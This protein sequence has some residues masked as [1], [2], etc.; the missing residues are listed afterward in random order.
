MLKRSSLLLAASLVVGLGVQAPAHAAATITGAGA[1][2]P[3]PVYSEWSDEYQD[4]TGAG[5]NYQAIGSGGGIQ[6]IQAGTVTFGASDAPLSADEQ[7]EHDLVQFP[8]IMGGVVP[9]ANLKLPEGKTLRLDGP[10]LAAIYQGKITSWDDK[11]IAALNEG[12]DLPSQ[13]ITPVYRS[14]GSGTNFNFT[15]YLAQVSD[16]FK[17]QVGEG[18]SVSWPAGVGAQANGGVASQVSKVPGAIGYVEYAYAKQ[19]HLPALELK[20]QDGSFVAPSGETFAAAASHADWKGTPGFDV[21]LTNQPGADSWPITAVSYILMHADAKDGNASKQA[22]DFFNWAY[23][24]GSEAATKLDYV[25]IPKDV[26][27]I[28]KENVWSR[29]KADGKPVWTEQ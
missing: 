3:Y 16:D 19:N 5:L 29:I 23:T 17:Q 9:V 27:E 8:M 28:V 7:K 25:A 2:F 13:R 15:H 20:N 24:N 6:Q 21:I 12:V 11:R 10:T 14:D 4:K 26:V 22:L 1:T 18:K